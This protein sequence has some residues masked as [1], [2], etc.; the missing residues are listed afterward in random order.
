M[1]FLKRNKKGYGWYHLVDTE[2][3]GKTKVADADKKF[4][5]FTFTKGTEPT[6]Q[7]LNDYG[8]YQGEL[9]FRDSTGAERKVYPYID[10]YHHSVAFH[11]VGKTNE[12]VDE[13]PT[14]IPKTEPKRDWQSTLDG[15]PDADYY[16]NAR[17]FT[18][19]EVPTEIDSNITEEDLP[20]L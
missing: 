15:K 5:D 12:Y 4:L 1:I 7:D 10:T 11:I 17:K 18:T 13:K 16:K 19:A 6:P 14:W 20:F 3:D 2:K 9:I 8:S